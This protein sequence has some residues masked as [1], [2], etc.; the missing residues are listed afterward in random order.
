[1]TL[2]GGDEH[3]ST[4]SAGIRWDIYHNTAL[5]IQYDR[6][7]DEGISS[8]ILGDSESLAFGIDV[9]F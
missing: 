7:K 2:A 4:R 6:V 5:K 3:H 9:V 8:A 1:L